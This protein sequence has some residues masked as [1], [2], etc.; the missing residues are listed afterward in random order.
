M[1]TLKEIKYFVAVSEELNFRKAAK[2]LNI[3][4]PP[5][6]KQIKILEEKLNLRLFERSKRGV[7]IT[8]AGNDFLKNCYDIKFKIN[9]SIESAKKIDKGELGNLKIGFSTLASFFILPKTISNFLRI[10]PNVELQLKEMRTE[11][12]ITDLKEKKIDI[13]FAGKKVVDRD[14]KSLSLF[15]ED[16]VLALEKTKERSIKNNKGHFYLYLDSFYLLKL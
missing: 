11:K 16:I 4:Q 2:K 5:L 6:S 3:S 12:I 13:G 1:I 7:K 8:L 10:Y 15:S 14:I 9:N